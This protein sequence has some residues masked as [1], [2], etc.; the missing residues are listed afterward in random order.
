[1]KKSA[2][3]AIFL[4]ASCA[5]SAGALG[6][7]VYR[8]GSNY[9]H[10]PCNGAVTIETQ[11]ARSKTQKTQSDQATVRDLATANSMEKDRKMVEARTIAQ[12]NA[13]LKAG[14][15]PEKKAKPRPEAETVLQAKEDATNAKPG[16]SKKKA[17]KKEVPGV[18]TAQGEAPKK[19]VTSA[20]AK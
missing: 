11:D 3:N 19:A 12:S 2:L 1:M 16:T 4:I 7:K 9:S 6:Q 17:K 13:V 18:F 15:A 5:I 10:I 14:Q 8:C 20:P